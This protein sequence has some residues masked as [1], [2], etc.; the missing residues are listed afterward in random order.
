MKRPLGALLACMLFALVTLNTA[1]AQ[2]DAGVRVVGSGLVNPVLESV[3]PEGAAPVF[4]TTGSANGLD[5]LCQGSADVA[6]ATRTINADEGAKCTTNSIDYSEMM[7]AHN[8]VALITRTDSP[9]PICLTAADINTLL[10]P[11]AEGQITNWNQLSGGAADSALALVVPPASSPL[12]AILDTLVQGDGLR[13]DVQ[14]TDGDTAIIEA[15][16][17]NPGMLGI[18]SLLS[19]LALGGDIR[20]VQVNANEVVGCTSPSAEAVEAGSYP[21]NQSYFV[22]VNRA[23]LTKP[24]LNDLMTAVTGSS[25]AAVLAGLGLTSVT[26]ASIERNGI[27]LAGTGEKRPYSAS[28]TDFQIPAQFS[29]TATIGGSAVPREYINGLLTTFQQSYPGAT[30]NL[31]TRGEVEGIRRLCNGEIEIALATADLNADQQAACAANSVT[32]LPVELGQQAVV[33]VSSAESSYLTCLTTS[34]LTTI[35][36]AE[37]AATANNLTTWNQVDASFPAE[38]MTLFTPPAG[39]S[40]ADLLMIQSAGRSTPMRDDGFSNRD[41]LYR[42]AATANVAG[43]GGLTF[44]S[45]DEYQQVIANNQDRIQLVAVDGGNGCINPTEQTINDGSYPLAQSATLLIRESALTNTTVQSFVWY[46]ALDANYPALVA[47]G[48]QGVT[49]GSLPALRE[50]L[51]DAFRAS[52][53]AAA[54]A[55]A[56]ATPEATAESTAE[57]T[58]GG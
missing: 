20:V 10:A 52:T 30:I 17:Q 42:A 45:W 46:M 3:T 43:G 22:Y 58:P 7:I 38:T 50:R 26:P 13:P 49:F 53:E 2:D 56:E 54:A 25:D 29:E 5:L 31:Q 23:S 39:N 4:E 48:F 51:Q 33:L 19:A 15:V 1:F 41:P 21:L 16:Q 12:Y 18:V 36:S 34:Q 32:L 47:A 14:V 8:V 37:S 35:W 11:S 55:A 24:G 9:A 44:M 6:T 28:V 40:Y 57:A 27:A